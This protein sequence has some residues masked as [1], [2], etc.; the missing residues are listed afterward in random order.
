MLLKTGERYC[1]LTLAMFIPLRHLCDL[2][3][4][5]SMALF[6]GVAL[7]ENDISNNSSA[8]AI[9]FPLVEFYSASHVTSVFYRKHKI[10]LFEP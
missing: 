5:K 1:G 9:Y 4:V 8:N 7:I 10:F 6:G 3:G 2:L